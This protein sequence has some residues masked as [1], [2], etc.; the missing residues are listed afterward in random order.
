MPAEGNNKPKNWLQAWGQASEIY[1]D[2]C[3]AKFL[4]I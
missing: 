4:T 2:I 3:T 1:G